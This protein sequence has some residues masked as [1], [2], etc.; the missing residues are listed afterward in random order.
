M[1]TEMV[2]INK[3]LSECGV[4][5]RR[6]SEEL[7][8]QGRVSVNDK[9][10]TDLA[11]KINPGSD[12]VKVDGES[13]SKEKKVYYVLNKPKG[14]ITTTDDERNRDTVLDLVKTDLAVFPVGR[15]DY[16]TTGVLI[17]TNDGDFANLLT[18]PSNDIP[19]VYE[20]FLSKPLSQED[21]ATLLKGVYIDGKKGWFTEIEIPSIKSPKRVVVTAAEGRNHFVK[22][23]FGA[24]GYMVK[25]LNRN[26]F[27]GITVDDIP[28]G[29]YKVL[30]MDVVKA[31]YK[32][33]A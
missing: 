33:Y 6:K 31:I 9:I 27:A 1:K 30:D 18:H 3:Y 20:V 23:M 26:S 19:R 7:V 10:I 25:S 12:S 29:T 5:S 21:K 2:R 4:A 28:Q 8:L 15:L 17:I 11:T 32:K 13:V 22:N 14:C 16:N 24:L